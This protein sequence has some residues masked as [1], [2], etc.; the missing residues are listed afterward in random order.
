MSRQRFI[1]MTTPLA[2]ITDLPAPDIRLV[3]VSGE[4][5]IGS[6][7]ALRDWIRS[8]GE[9]ATH[10]VLVD[11]NA[12]TFLSGCAL[13]VLCDEQELLLD[14]GHSLVLVCDRPELLS[15][16]RLVE[17]DDIIAVVP[18]RASALAGFQRRSSQRP[19]DHLAAW[20]AAHPAT[21][22]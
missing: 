1:A 12:V 22:G 13:H 5:D 6:A 15:L 11:L 16:L 14:Q 10:D 9:G 17:L 20:M 4:L 18:D 19:S 7:P 2:L 3:S 8:A 21:L